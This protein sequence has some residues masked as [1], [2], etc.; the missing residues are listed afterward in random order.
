MTMP[1]WLD[2]ATGGDGGF[3]AVIGLRPDLAAAYRDF[4]A[5]FWDDAL[6]DPVALELC[7]LRVA[8]LLRCP[9]ALEERMPAATA[10]GLT[11][12]LVGALPA[13]STDSRF[14]DLQRAALTIAEQFVLDPHGIT[15]EQR[16]A[17]VAHAGDAGLVALVEALAVFDGFTRFRTILEVS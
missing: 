9:G 5:V 3:D 7:R 4:A 14:T 8:Q 10:A 2:D 11:E 16:A 6:F 15:A 13:W 17:V 1:S 12:E